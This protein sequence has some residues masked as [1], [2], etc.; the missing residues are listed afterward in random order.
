MYD[1]KASDLNVHC[2][3]NGCNLLLDEKCKFVMVPLLFW[4]EFSV[5]YSV[6]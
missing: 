5:F 6:L 4:D 1:A 2:K 3:S